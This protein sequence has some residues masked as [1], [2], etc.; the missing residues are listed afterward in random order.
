MIQHLRC[1][2]QPSILGSSETT[3]EAP[4]RCFFSFSWC[5]NSSFVKDEFDFSNYV[6]YGTPKQIPCP[7]VDFL[8]WFIGFSE[9]DGNFIFSSKRFYF[10]INQKDPKLLFHIRKRLGFGKV[11]SYS[12]KG[13][14]YYRFQVSDRQGIRRLFYLFNGNLVLEKTN[15]KFVDW[16]TNANLIWNEKLKNEKDRKS[17]DNPKPSLENAWFSGFIESDGGFY[18]RVLKNNRYK[19]GFQLQMKFYMT[20]LGEEKILQNLKQILKSNA[21]LRQIQTNFQIYTRLDINGVESHSILLKYLE[22]YPCYGRKNIIIQQWKKIYFRREKEEHLT[23]ISI[24]K[25]HQLCRN[26]IKSK[27]KYQDESFENLLFT[28]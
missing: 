9:G 2:K 12:Q 23:E 10:V 26:L 16:I 27:T 6:L 11:Q 5:S 24:Q 19:I 7:D 18:A 25:L 15:Q 3:R 22:E 21:T 17:K 4:F 14:I 28:S 20:Q 8:T 1:V 13:E